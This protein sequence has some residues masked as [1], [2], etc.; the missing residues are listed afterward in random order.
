MNRSILIVICDFLVLSAMSL[1]MGIS[2]TTAQGTG[3]T[4]SVRPVTHVFLIEQLEKAVKMQKAAVGESDKLSKD[5]SNAE[6]VLAELR[7]TLEKRDQRMER[8]EMTLANMTNS[9]SRQQ[10]ELLDARKKAE[11]LS[12]SLA[13]AKGN[14]SGSQRELLDK[15]VAL[16]A[17]RKTIDEQDKSLRTAKMTLVQQSALL[18]ISKEEL[19]KKT[20][21][22]EKSEKTLTDKSKELTRMILQVER[23]EAMIRENQKR[24]AEKEAALFRAEVLAAERKTDLQKVQ[25]EYVAVATELDNTHKKLKLASEDNAYTEGLLAKANEELDKMKRDAGTRQILLNEKTEQLAAM[26]V[27]M[28]EE[29]TQKAMLKTTLA[30]RDA[31]V[32]QQQTQLQDKER[33]ITIQEE[34][35]KTVNTRLQAKDEVIRQT[36]KTLSKTEKDL[37][38]ASSMLRSDALSAYAKSTAE[39]RFILKNDRLF[40]TFEL[41]ETYYLPRI[42]LGGKVFLPGAFEKLTGLTEQRNGYSTV[43]ALSYTAKKPGAANNTA[44]KLE[45]PIYVLN[46]DPRA[47][48]IE[49]PGEKQAAMPALTASA[50][51]KRGLQNLTLFKANRYGEES[52]LLDGRCSM[53]PNQDQYLMI[54]NSLRSSSEVPAAV[55]DFVVAREG[56]LAGIIVRVENHPAEGRADAYCFIFPSSIDLEKA[57]PLTLKR[58]GGRYPYR[59]FVQQLEKIHKRILDINRK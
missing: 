20:A 53:R 41:D 58:D 5:L 18:R 34:R 23:N 19:A 29:M 44:E 26:K 51:R 11:E 31:Q 30:E 36:Q 57:S 4:E 6:R 12:S 40:N 13:L 10:T 48:L 27:K 32:K 56:G 22:L 38:R 46:E 9:M 8:L 25:K 7:A 43:S 52:A 47:C 2:K 15:E 17:A 49:L 55:G 39:V 1:S 59:S 24:I 21:E 3:V 42:S 50:L 16:A 14:L 45:G 54:R 28:A 37:E 33:V 35:M